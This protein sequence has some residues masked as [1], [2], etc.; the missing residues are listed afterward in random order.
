[1]HLAAK[2]KS[3]FFDKNA[4]T[5]LEIADWLEENGRERDILDLREAALNWLIWEDTPEDFDSP[6]KRQALSRFK[7]ALLDVDEEASRAMFCFSFRDRWKKTDL[8]GGRYKWEQKKEERVT[9]NGTILPQ[10]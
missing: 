5:G 3:A 4:V 1:M 9:P 6:E 10:E 2:I 8:G 7:N